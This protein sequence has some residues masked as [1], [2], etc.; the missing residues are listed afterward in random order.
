MVSSECAK[1]FAVLLDEEASVE[2]RDAAL[3]CL[4]TNTLRSRLKHRF[5]SYECYVPFTFDDA[6]QEFFLYLRGDKTEVYSVFKKL[7]DHSAADSWLVSTFRNFISRKARHS[8]PQGPTIEHH[9]SDITLDPIQEIQKS[10]M[11]P[12]MIA[13]CYQELP[14]VQR[15]VLLRMILSV[16]DRDRALP[17]KDVAMVLGISHVYY[18]VL[19]NRVKSFTMRVNEKLLSGEDLSLDSTALAMQKAMENRT[20][21]WYELIAEY[22]SQ[23]I[24]QFA[25]SEA[26]KALRCSY[27]KDSSAKILHDVLNP[28]YKSSLN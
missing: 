12:M 15:F 9:I 19:G 25:Q 11:L 2:V 16:L 3:Y 24:E 22:Y 23:T 5:S 14:L 28:Y 27:C 1:M 10:A 26:I 18:R 6:L 7:K 20:I 13:Y 8:V 21:G 17:Q 4:I